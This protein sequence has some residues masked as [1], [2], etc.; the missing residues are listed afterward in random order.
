[1]VIIQERIDRKEGCEL[2]EREQVG[3]ISGE[4]LFMPKDEAAMSKS[5]KHRQQTGLFGWAQDR[6]A[7]SNENDL[8]K[9]NQFLQH[10]CHTSM[11]LAACHLRH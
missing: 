6:V 5:H 9:R 10:S 8:T 7:T 1:M 2:R 11:Q 3:S 4:T